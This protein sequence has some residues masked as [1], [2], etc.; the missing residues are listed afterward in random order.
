MSNGSQGSV[1][2]CVDQMQ[3]LSETHPDWYAEYEDSQMD[4]GCDREV[5]EG[6]L[7]TAPTPFA[8]GVM[9][10]KIMFRQQVASL[11]ERPF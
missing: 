2:L 9:F 7:T 5:L 11:T 3:K 8:Q 6:L 10:G 1:V 4:I